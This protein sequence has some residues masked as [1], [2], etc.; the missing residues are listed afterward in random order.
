MADT[1]EAWGE[2]WA[3]VAGGPERT[4]TIRGITVTV[5]KDLPIAVEHR[6][7]VLSESDKYD[8]MAELVAL[9]FG[10]DALDQWRDTGMG[11][12]ELQTILTWGMAQASGTDITF[13]QA[14]DAVT[15]ADGE[16]K[17]AAP[18]GANRA[19]RRAQSASTG[20]RS[21]PTSSASTGSARK[22]SRT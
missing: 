11:M 18:K 8:D 2:F 1:N 9:L 6:I 21:R 5:P 4:E 16:G 7:E 13:R 22:T 12:L 10:V 20:G 3:E 17:P 19:A 15:G 14:Y